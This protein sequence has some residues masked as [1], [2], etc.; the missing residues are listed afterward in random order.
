[1]PVYNRSDD[2][3][4]LAEKVYTCQRFRSLPKSVAVHYSRQPFPPFLVPAGDYIR[5]Y[6]ECLWHSACLQNN[7]ITVGGGNLQ[8]C[9][10]RLALAVD[11]RLIEAP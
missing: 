9:Q 8:D 3:R 4:T 11:A 5:T 1:M 10:T 2:T 7:L 6:A